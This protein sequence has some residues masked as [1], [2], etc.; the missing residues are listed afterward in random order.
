MRFQTIAASSMLLAVLSFTASAAKSECDR[1]ID[2]AMNKIEPACANLPNIGRIEDFADS[3]LTSQHR[4]CFCAIPP[5]SDWYQHCNHPETCGAEQM[6]LIAQL[7]S[8]LTTKTV[9]PAPAS[10]SAG[11]TATTTTT[12]GASG[13]GVDIMAAASI[14]AFA[15]VFGIML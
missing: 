4:K 12:S 5:N 3:K 6:S 10:S 11:A 8:V 13:K 14:V 9:C 1:C 15:A 2:S 7:V